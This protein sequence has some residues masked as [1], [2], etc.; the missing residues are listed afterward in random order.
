VLSRTLGKSHDAHATSPI[1]HVLVAREESIKVGIGNSSEPCQVGIVNLHVGAGRIANHPT[2]V[3]VC[4]FGDSLASQ[5]SAN[6][7]VQA[8]A[9]ILR[10]SALAMIRMPT[11]VTGPLASQ[12]Y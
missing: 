5:A 9:R 11:L 8:C 3:A 6:R 4:W 10:G 12:S 2:R 7:H 1:T